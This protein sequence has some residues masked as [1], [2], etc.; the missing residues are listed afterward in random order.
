MGLN[1]LGGGS[2]F[3]MGDLAISVFGG[4]FSC[5]GK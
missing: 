2:E 5:M 3:V 4:I 1:I